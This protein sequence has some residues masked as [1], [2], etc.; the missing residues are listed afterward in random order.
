MKRLIVSAV[1]GGALGAILMI[2]VLFLTHSYPSQYNKCALACPGG[3][4]IGHY[5][6]DR[7]RVY[8]CEHMERHR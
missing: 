7:A 6:I 3:R 1:I 5:G 2:L 8:P 4:G